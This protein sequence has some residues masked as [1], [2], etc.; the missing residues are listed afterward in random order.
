MLAADEAHIH[1]LGDDD[2]P[3]VR[4]D[5]GAEELYQSLSDLREI[6]IGLHGAA[7]L[8]PL[9]IDVMPAKDPA[10]IMGVARETATAL[11]RITLP[12]SR[13]PNAK[14]D[15][16]GWARRLDK[17]RAVVEQ[18]VT[19]VAREQ[20]EAETTLVAKNNSI[21]QH[22]VAQRALAGILSGLLDFIGESELADRV[23][24]TERKSR[25][26]KS[27]GDDGGGGGESGG[28]GSGTGG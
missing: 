9:R 17:E 12:P 25:K 4:R 7:I 22:D 10:V 3:R 13:V 1:E 26:A 19:D 8:A 6:A 5:A 15:T 23:R 16:E 24:P 11:R 18:A 28:G 20:R 2:E 14:L 21:A 27:G